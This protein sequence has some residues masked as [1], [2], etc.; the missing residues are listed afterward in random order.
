MPTQSK[1]YRIL[2]LRTTASH[3]ELPC[4]RRL[5][6]IDGHFESQHVLRAEEFSR[7]RGGRLLRRPAH[8]NSELFLFCQLSVICARSHYVHSCPS[9]LCCRDGFA[10]FYLNVSGIKRDRRRPPP[11]KPIDTESLLSLSTLGGIPTAST[12]RRDVDWHLRL[13]R[14]GFE[15]WWGLLPDCPRGRPLP[16]CRKTIVL[17]GSGQC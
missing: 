6:H 16:R 17:D 4:S 15:S 10:G 7:A 13:V 12:N 14:P 9:N 1:Q 5:R 8:S 3:L 11:K 2:F